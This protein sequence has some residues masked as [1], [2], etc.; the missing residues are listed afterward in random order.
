VENKQLISKLD[1]ITEQLKQIADNI[2]VSVG[3]TTKG[4]KAKRIT[5][6]SR[7]EKIKVKLTAL[8]T[9]KVY[10]KTLGL[11]FN[12]KD[13]DK[14]VQRFRIGLK[15][16]PFFNL[17][18]RSF[19]GI[20]DFFNKTYTSLNDIKSLYAASGTNNQL[21][22]DEIKKSNL[23]LQD[24][25]DLTLNDKT[26]KD[27]VDAVVA[28]GGSIALTP[29]YDTVLTEVS[30][31]LKDVVLELKKVTSKSFEKARD[32]V[33]SVDFLIKRMKWEDFKTQVLG[34]L[35]NLIKVNEEIRDKKSS[36]SETRRRFTTEKIFTNVKGIAGMLLIGGALFLIVNA[37]IS[38]KL[39][40]VTQ[41]LKVIGVMSALT[42]VFALL[43]KTF[44]DIE[45]VSIGIKNFITAVGMFTGLAL[46]TSLINADVLMKG[47]VMISMVSLLCIGILKGLSYLSN[48]T[49]QVSRMA[50]AIKLF[51]H[52]VAM[53]IPLALITSLINFGFLMTGLLKLLPVIGV[54][55]GVL[56]LISKIKENDVV[57]KSKALS[58]FFGMITFL[59]LP[60][61]IFISKIKY[62]TIMQ[63]LLNLGIAIGG[64]TS[65]FLGLGYLV[66]NFK[67]KLITGA[68]AF[69]GV[70]VLMAILAKVFDYFTQ[71]DWNVVS[72]GLINGLEAI[73][74][75]GIF[76]AALGAS[77]EIVGPLLLSGGIAMLGL[78]FLMDTFAESITKFNNIKADNLEKLGIGLKSLSLG[79]IS[80]LGGSVTG[81][82]SSFINSVASFFGLD[83]ASEI[84][85]FENINADKIYKLGTGLKFMS[86]SLKDLSSGI[87]LKST[88]NEI[89]NIVKPLEAFSN[90]LD[91]FGNSYSNLNKLNLN[92][93]YNLKIKEDTSIQLAIKELNEQELAVQKDQLDQLR[94][95]GEW[96]RIISERVGGG[97][98][99]FLPNKN[100]SSQISSPNFETKNNFADSLK[101]VS[102]SFA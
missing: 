27:I 99:S 39:I 18:E 52:A 66:D 62:K 102:M 34:R 80:F 71:R 87:N 32:F 77:I 50:H 47:L 1:K 59:L 64:L 76:V 85:K 65:I 12:V 96:L 48:N 63:G 36:R 23:I 89:I 44:I 7:E 51:S 81:I 60:S 79:L 73:G 28:L 16:T 22:I 9:A 84:K 55:L 70:A 67:G 5:V 8:E 97:S 33:K 13:V 14:T 98:T 45:Q 78:M 19:I 92:S 58:L 94:R 54:C 40:D 101:M 53:F 57:K 75:F 93:E 29:R 20:K 91:K 46:I 26:N 100:N 49:K 90:A 6:L 74:I 35:D 82:T 42:I 17:I 41:I 61:L 72:E 88:V 4:G 69:A 95:N 83:P 2:G 31:S 37:L 86:D 11:G 10:K 43:S 3:I 30:N 15:L 21:V 25:L 38:T 24:I 56:F 68:I